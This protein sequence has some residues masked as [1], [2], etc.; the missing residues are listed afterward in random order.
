M[1]LSKIL[2]N[3]RNV[4]ENEWDAAIRDAE[5]EIVELARQKA[6]LESAVRVFRQ[7]KLEGME[8]PEPK[9]RTGKD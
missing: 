9:R 2:S 8:W 5:A 6:R 3:D 4:K 1:N 7:N